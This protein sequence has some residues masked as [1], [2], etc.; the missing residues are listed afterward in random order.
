V[1][2][3]LRILGLVAMTGILV[4]CI[5]MTPA[6]ETRPLQGNPAQQL[7]DAAGKA[8]GPGGVSGPCPVRSACAPEDQ[9]SAALVMA[10][11]AFLIG[12]VWCV[13]AAAVIIHGLTKRTPATPTEEDQP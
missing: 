10:R 6:A 5:T 8:R 7:Y 1:S 4:N 2:W 3:L 9:V 12:G 13:F 11:V